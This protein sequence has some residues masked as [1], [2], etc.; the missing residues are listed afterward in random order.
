MYVIL[1]IIANG[2][3]LS[4]IR[5]FE[6]LDCLSP[7]FCLLTKNVKVRRTCQS[8]FLFSF[9]ISLNKRRRFHGCVCVSF[10]HLAGRNNKL[11][12]NNQTLRHF[13]LLI[14]K[15]GSIFLLNISFFLSCQAKGAPFFLDR[16]VF[17]SS[18]QIAFDSGHGRRRRAEKICSRSMERHPS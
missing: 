13:Q 8:F 16:T 14:Q 5:R 10:K 6:N 17:C 12:K 15:F 7:F 11:S 3:I 18:T 4:S 1:H 2:G 9:S